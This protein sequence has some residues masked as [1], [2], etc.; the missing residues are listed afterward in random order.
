MRKEVYALTDNH[1]AACGVHKSQAACKQW[2]EAHEIY[3]INYNEGTATMTEIVPLCH[4]CHAFIHSGLLR[5]RARKKE[6][7]ADHVRQV[8]RHG[9]GILKQ[10][11]GQKIFAGT[12]VL[13]KL[14]SVSTVGLRTT[15]PPQRMADWP[16]WRM[17][18]DGEEYRGAFKSFRQWHERYAGA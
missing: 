11:K 6:I 13:A 8:I 7:S 1:C 17:V 10:S 16:K 15:S 3:D 4:F 9:V 12:A 18:W 5:I 14:V 2:M